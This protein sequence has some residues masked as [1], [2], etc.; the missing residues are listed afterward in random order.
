MITPHKV[1]FLVSS[2]N[3]MWI[4]SLKVTFFVG[5]LMLP[6]P[7]ISS[8]SNNEAKHKKKKSK[9][10]IEGL[11]MLGSVLLRKWF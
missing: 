8:N 6:W 5:M 7:Q 2:F 1:P 4:D 9:L 10:A 11:T 3:S